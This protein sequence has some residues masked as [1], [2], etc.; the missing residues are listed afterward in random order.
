[1]DG[2]ISVA[3]NL[4]NAGFDPDSGSIDASVPPAVYALDAAPVGLMIP[5]GLSPELETAVLAV[6]ADLDSRIA[7]LRGG[8][9]FSDVDF[10]L[11]CLEHGGVSKARFE[12]DFERAQALASSEAPPVAPPDSPQ[13]AAL[14]VRLA[15]IRSLN[16]GC[17]SCGGFAYD[18]LMEV[19]LDAGL[20]IEGPAFDA[21]YD[22]G[23]WQVVILAC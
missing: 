19:D 15:A 13:A 6:F 11:R 9:M 14:A 10:K 2:A 1:L 12:D 23:A 8:V 16:S 18:T 22:D 3:A 5:A 4:F 20:I 7:S 17:D 21:T